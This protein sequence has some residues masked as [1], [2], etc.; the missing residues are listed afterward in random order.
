VQGI[1]WSPALRS[2]VTC[3]AAAGT[4]GKSVERFLG[5][6]RRVHGPRTIV[7]RGA[8]LRISR[9]IS[10]ALAGSVSA[11]KIFL[12]TK[13]RNRVLI[14]TS[15]SARGAFRDRHERWMQDAVDAKARET[16]D[17]FADDEAVWS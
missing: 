14:A 1:D 11:T 10:T 9:A 13:I 15:C 5:A 2:I 6:P 8:Q 3:F 16:N 17:V 7:N 12:F 4:T